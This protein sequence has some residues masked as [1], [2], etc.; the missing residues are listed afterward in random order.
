M[1]AVAASTPSRRPSRPGARL[2]HYRVALLVATLAAAHSSA[3]T[4]PTASPVPGG[5][6]L[7]DLGAATGAPPS[8]LHDAH[9]VLVRSDGGRFVAVVG[10]PLSATPGKDSISVAEPGGAPRT[11]EFELKPKEYVTQAL[12][13][14]PGKVDL[15][16]ESV[17]RDKREKE[18][19][20]PVFDTF[21]ATAPSTL[22]L[23]TPV[24]GIRSSSFGSRRVF[25][26]QARNPHTGMDIAAGTG[27]PVT[28][29]ADGVVL[30][31][32]DYFFNGNTVIIDHG[33]GLLTMYCHLSATS[34]VRGERVTVGT[35]LGKVG[36]TGRVTGPHLHFG[37]MLNR[38]WIDPQLLLAP[39][40]AAAA[41]G[42]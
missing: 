14:D 4:L 1:S 37:V 10:I 36:A 7:V 18:H 24:P 27:T 15:S 12:T 19:L 2:R 5:I 8:V 23:A 11:V 17:A 32:G 41:P 26:G 39:P 21:S 30:D 13:V 29:P 42:A 25:N 16:A 22:S 3:A 9:R 20:G 6:A 38:A 33:Q 40:A 34:V 28:A 31:T 35:V